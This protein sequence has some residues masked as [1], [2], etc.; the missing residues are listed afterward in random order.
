MAINRV[1]GPM[2]F[3][4]L[5]RQGVDLQFSTNGQPALYLDLTNFRIGVNTSTLTESITIN[6]NLSAG[7]V[8]ISGN[9][10]YLT[11]AADFTISSYSGNVKIVAPSGVVDFAG[12]QITNFMQ[13]TGSND[14][15]TRSYVD[16][17]VANVFL[18][19]ISSGTTSVVTSTNNILLTVSGTTVATLTNNLLSATNAQVT[20]LSSGNAQITGGAITGTPISGSTG[21]FTTLSASGGITGTLQTASQPNVTGL[22]TIGTLVATNFSTGNAQVTGGAISGTPISGST[23]SFTTLSASGGITG[24]LSTAAQP[25]ITSLGTLIVLNTANAQITGGSITNTPISG[26]TGGFTTLS[27]S[28]GINNT[29]IG[30]TTPAAGSFTTLSA[31]SGITGTLSTAAQ[32]NVTSLG[33][34]T[35]LTITGN[36]TVAGILATSLNAQSGN[37]QTTGT[38]I[39]TNLQG[40]LTTAAQPNITSVGTLTSL[41]VSGGI[42]GSTLTGTLQT[43]A[44]TNV[45][46]LGTLTGLTVSGVTSI[47][48]AT[49]SSGTAS[50]ALVVTGG[51]GVGKNLYVGGDTTITGNLTIL[52]TQNVVNSTTLAIVDPVV[53]IGTGANNAPLTTDDGVDR[54]IRANYYKG[55]AKAAFFGFQSSTQCFEYLTDASVTSG[56]FS[57]TAGKAMFGALTLS[58][59][60]PSTSATTGTL[61]SSGG[62]GITGNLNVAGITTV[63]PTQVSGNN[64]LV[65][66]VADANL[67]CA[68]TVT[69]QIVLGGNTGPVTGAKVTINSTDSIL[70][71][72]GDSTQRPSSPVAGMQRYNSAL[73][74]IEFWNGSGWAV[75]NG[76]VFTSITDQQFTG[77]GV[78]TTYTLSQASTSAGTIVV[79]AGAIK[80]PSVDYTVVGTTL[81]FTSAPANGAA[82]DA[83]VILTTTSVTSITSG[84]NSIVSDATGLRFYVGTSSTTEVWDFTTAGHFVPKTTNSYN[85]GAS[86]NL[87]A[88]VYATNV[89]GT[90]TTAAQPN[91]TSVGTLTS[92]SV[93]GTVTAGGFSG[94]LTGT[95]QTAAQPNITSVGTLTSLVVSG[96][97]NTGSLQSANVWSTGGSINASPI[98]NVTPSTGAF[99]TLSASGGITGTLSTAAQPNITSVGTLTSLSVTGGITGSTL[100]GTLQTAA[101]TNITSVGTLTGLTVSGSSTFQNAS[102]NFTASNAGLEIGST[103]ASNSPYIDF[104]SSGNNIDYDAR[105]L[106]SGGNASVGY[107]VLTVTA[108]NVTLTGNLLTSANGVY[109]VGT[110]VNRFGIFYGTATTAQYA[111]LAEN[112]LAD[113]KYDAGTV[114]EFGGEKEVTISST[115]MST[116]V[117]GVVSTNPAHLMNATLTGEFVTPLAL[118]GRVPM[119]VYGPVRKG[120]M[121]VSAGNGY[122]RAEENPKLGSVIG[123]ALVDFTGVV[124]LIEVVVGRL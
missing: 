97:T 15:A 41:T 66:G 28:G 63:N 62:V 108:A 48:N 20:N 29:T 117:A 121:I 105:I 120:D 98:G 73:N 83:R 81:T 17:K 38:V 86:G 55:S 102:T 54:G 90:L 72:V 4:D 32:P 122:G 30:Q 91:I 34:L 21:S 27:A 88:T 84:Y 42:T 44:Q 11:Q 60:T 64:L 52:G 3:S 110:S 70:L 45:T 25:N 1:S 37:I 123:K 10:I 36:L 18:P 2:L 94:P 22:G 89:Q 96:L 78:Q 39:G 14:V 80:T 115:D 106:A 67:F 75:Y 16:S 99:T 118:Q 79:V 13:G 19:N 5:D 124:G 57:G 82:I 26:S 77:N 6:G 58:N 93:T 71:P 31:T 40:T 33:T 68:N 9:G 12:T 49:Q 92:L 43:A 65:K 87:V 111:D 100:T 61:V 8:K 112:Y 50:G 69:N 35:N 23:G 24:T 103:G 74:A 59:A 104:H 85:V 101:Q 119:Y 51:L 107:G 95:I 56:V 76:T 109:N 116:R 114:L 53:D 113:A 46:S 47:T 7:P